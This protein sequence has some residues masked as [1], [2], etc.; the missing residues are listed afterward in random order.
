MLTRK[1]SADATARCAFPCPRP[2][3]PLDPRRPTRETRP[4]PLVALALL[5]LAACGALPESTRFDDAASWP[6]AAEARSP[7]AMVVTGS[8]IATRIGA[9][10]LEQGGNAVDAAIAAAFA[11]SVVEPSMSGLGGRTQILLRRADGSFVG[12]DGTTQ[13]PPSYAVEPPLADEGAYGYPTVAI[14]GTVAALARA[15]DEHGTWPL[16]RVLAPAIAVAEHGFVLP[17]DEAARIAAAAERLREFAGSRRYFLR[18]DGTPLRA[19]DVFVQ[20]DLAR[21]LRRIADHG[22]DDFYRGEIARRLVRDVTSGGGTLSLDDLARYE[23][24]DA[25]VVRGRYRGRELI[26]TYLPAS[27][28]TTIQ[29]MQMLEHFDLPRVVGTSDWVAILAQALLIGFADRAAE[30]G[31]PEQ[32]AR[33]LTSPEWAAERAAAIRAPTAGPTHEPS[34]ETAAAALAATALDLDFEPEHTT[35]LSV[36][37]AHGGAVALTQSVGPNMGAVAAADGLGF[38]YAATM[39]YLGALRAGARPSSSISPLIVIEDGRPA[40]VLGA[41]GARRII[42]AIVAVLSRAIDGG[43]AFPDAMRAPRLHALA[44]RI[45]VEVR[46][47]AA[48]AD[49]AIG[50]LRGLGFTVRERAEPPYFGRIHGIAYD[51]RTRSYI[52]VSDPR[53]HGGAASPRAR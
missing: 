13:V 8:P 52:G 12:I 37:D 20:R 45:D 42:P 17:A 43:D 3:P 29:V 14:P 28:A 33:L 36:V 32:K 25:L 21:T 44:D 9:R 5:L 53:W 35:H 1:L 31:A 39:G 16:A 22:A 11:L 49:T 6:V 15:L 26:G 48:W 4:R 19:G 51:A 27:G 2:R 23:A 34:V 30:L 50:R 24:A 18:P 47:G 10:V 40:F 46:P 41:A 7:A 38:V